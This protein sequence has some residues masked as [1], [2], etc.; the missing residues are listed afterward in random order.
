M[1]ETA[2]TRAQQDAISA[3]QG[4]V[5][6]AAAAGSGKT[7]VLVQR[8]IERLTDRENPVPADRLL[9]VTFTK[10]AAQE[11]R[12]RLEQRLWGL[13]RE[14]PEN[15]VLR[16]QS[17]LLP[18]AHIGTVD[19]F[20]AEMVRE[21]FQAVSYRAEMN[22]HLKQISGINNHH[23][24]EASFKAFARALDEASG[25]EPRIAGVW[26]TKGSL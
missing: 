22:L 5:L 16:R 11:M 20:C 3:R 25:F 18:Q 24:A 2:W 21:F 7:A 13:I 14:N 8:A 17:L 4:T 15:P 26:S 9:I 10:A 23:I 1:A 19:S 12:A 6:V